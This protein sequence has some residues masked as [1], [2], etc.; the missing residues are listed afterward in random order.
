MTESPKPTNTQ[1]ERTARRVAFRDGIARGQRP[2][3]PR[4]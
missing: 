4:W 3:R 1:A 2:D